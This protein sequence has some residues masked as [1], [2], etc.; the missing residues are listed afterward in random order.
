[1]ESR[2]QLPEFRLIKL[3]ARGRWLQIISALSSISPDI[4]DSRKH[5]CPKCGGDNRFRAYDDFNQEGGLLCSHCHQPSAKTADGFA[6]L[7]WLNGWTFQESI[8]AVAEELGLTRASAALPKPKIAPPI[9]AKPAKADRPAADSALEFQEWNEAVASIWCMKKAPIKIEALKAFGARLARYQK[10]TV[11]VALPI[12]GEQLA[13]GEPV[14]WIVY[15]VTGGTLQSKDGP[16][17]KKVTWGSDTGLVG[18]VDRLRDPAARRIKTEGPTDGLALLSMNL[19]TSDAIFC[20]ACGAIER[21]DKDAFNWLP[22]LVE[23]SSCVTVGDADHAGEE[24]SKRW[25]NFFAATASASR[26]VRLPYDIVPSHGKDLRDYF[27]EGKSIDEF[28]QLASAGQLVEY[29]PPEAKRALELPEDPHRLAR[30]N[31]EAYR[32]EHGGELRFWRGQWLKWKRNRYAFLTDKEIES[33]VNY[34]IKIEFDKQ[35]EIDHQKHLQALATDPD[36]NKEAPTARKVTTSIVRDTLAALRSMCTINSSVEMGT[37]IQAKEPRKYLACK[38]CI[39]DIAAFLDG[40]PPEQVF[41]EHSPNWFSTACLNYSFDPLA[42][43][44]LWDAILEQM[45]GDEPEKLLLAQEFAGYILSPSNNRSKFLALEGEGGNGKS[46]FANAIEAIIGKENTS[47]VGLDV[48]GRRFQAFPTLGK[49]LNICQEANDIEGPAESFLK[50]FTGGNPMMFEPKQKDAFSAIP[51]AKL[52]LTWNIAPRF[53]DRSEGLWRRM[54]VLRFN[55]KPERPNPELLQPDFWEKNG[56]LL[57]CST[58]LC[59]G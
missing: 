48:I 42:T 14:G 50:N 51:T 17:T 39:L 32:A 18:L 36:Y 40:A 53:K 1:M 13:Q 57:A 20:N 9:N 38:N 52:L 2:K 49:M 58:G 55:R 59:L 27:A 30:A 43:C 19:S 54:L 47:A 33:K 6:S 22:S 23:N 21:P 11:C 28:E 12:W 8:R 29:V 24:G 5:P 41:L 37:W 46:V 35:W 45:I 56:Q 16:V 34:R 26:I 7:Q 25:A 10:K 44:P 3:Q 31:I 15:N 4:L